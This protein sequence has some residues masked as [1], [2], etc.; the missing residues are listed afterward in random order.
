MN[1]LITNDDGYDA[2]GLRAAYHAVRSMGQVFVVA[3]SSEQSACSHRLTL[4]GPVHVRRVHHEPFGDTFMVDGTPAD[5]VRLAVHELVRE[6]IDLV[7]SG[8]NAGANA[9]VDVFYSGTIAAAREAAILGLPAIAL[10]HAQRDVETDWA[11]AAEVSRAIIADLLTDPLPAAG[12]WSVNFPA[13][14]PE[15]VHRH[16]HRV[17]LSMTAIPLEFH[18][19]EHDHGRVMEFAYPRNS[20]WSRENSLDTDFGVLANGGITLT[21]IPLMGK[22]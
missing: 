17:P 12:F 6:P 7:V 18:R 14:I 13:I 8:I 1:I 2:P 4:R 16:T 11:R 15:D 5:C 10:S 3:P 22:F 20:Y 21:P 19:Q 9:G